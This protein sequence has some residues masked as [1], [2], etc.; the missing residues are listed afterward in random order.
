HGRQRD[1]GPDGRSPHA[2]GHSPA[3]PDRGRRRGTRTLRTALRGGLR[4]PL[5]EDRQGPRRSRRGPSVRSGGVMTVPRRVAG[6]C[7][8][9]MHM[10]DL[11]RRAITS[12]R[13]DVVGVYDTQPRRMAEVCDDLGIGGELRYA[14][15]ERLL[16]EQRPEVAI[17]CS[18]T[19]EHADWGERLAGRRIHV[20]LEKA[21]AVSAD[22]S[23]V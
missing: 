20:L 19:A 6:F 7:F 13:Y 9:H 14:D 23:S 4:R 8:D 18:T 11:L 22:D 21:F 5:D 2:A 16:D 3:G 15:W 17:V 10:G 12:P 1:Q